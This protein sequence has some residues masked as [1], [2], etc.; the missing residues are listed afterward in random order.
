[1]FSA[2]NSQIPKHRIFFCFRILIQAYKIS[3]LPNSQKNSALELK[4]NAH[5]VFPES[6]SQP[7]KF[8]IPLKC[9]AT[10]LI[11]SQT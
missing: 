6:E 3:R 11:I 7:P 1:M 4:T 9:K 8:F 5:K 2:L 10:N